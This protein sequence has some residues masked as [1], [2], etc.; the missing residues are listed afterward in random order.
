MALPMGLVMALLQGPLQLLLVLPPLLLESP[1]LVPPQ[2]V[3]QLAPLQV[4]V[5]QAAPRE[6]PLT[7]LLPH[8]RRQTDEIW[9]ICQLSTV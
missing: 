5:Q 4:T 1:Q 8:R 2:L 3:P 7:V 6:V 9:K